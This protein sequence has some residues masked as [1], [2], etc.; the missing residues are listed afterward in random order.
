MPLINL[1]IL[2]KK[3][4]FCCTNYHLVGVM[5]FLVPLLTNNVRKLIRSRHQ[6]RFVLI[7][8]RELRRWH[9]FAMAFALR[10]LIIVSLIGVFLN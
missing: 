2:K 7:G 6:A 10:F 5:V 9:G 4:A 8:Q 3:S 1:R